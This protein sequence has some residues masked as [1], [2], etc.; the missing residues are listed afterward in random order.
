V[1]IVEYFRSAIK[2]STCS[3]LVRGHRFRASIPFRRKSIL[4][5]TAQDQILDEGLR[6]TLTESLMDGEVPD[7]LYL[8]RHKA[9]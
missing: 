6:V 9:R 4:R 1:L 7:D 2:R 8:L 3:A 5:Y